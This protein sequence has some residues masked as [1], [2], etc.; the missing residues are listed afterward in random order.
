MK[1]LE[2]QLAKSTFQQALDIKSGEKYPTNKITFIDNKLKEISDAKSDMEQAV[3]T[4]KGE[5][6]ADALFNE[7]NFE[8]ASL[9]Y[10]AAKKIKNDE[11]YPDQKI[12]EIKIKLTHIANLEKESQKKYLD[13]IKNADGSFKSQNWKLAKQFYNNA[14]SI[15]ESQE[16]PKKQLE[17]IEQKILDEESLMAESKEKLEKFNSLITQGDKS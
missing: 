2:Y 8:D 17:I 13:F 15:D 14:L 11:S 6:K 12:N 1:N 7:D 10:Q 3:L 9:S 5:F 4:S 16:Y